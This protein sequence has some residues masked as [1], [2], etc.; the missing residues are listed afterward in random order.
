M[1]IN[2]NRMKF[3]AAEYAAQHFK[4]KVKTERSG[5]KMMKKKKKK[6]KKKKK[7]NLYF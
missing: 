6:T 5:S 7:I 2:T 3:R 1:S 4:K